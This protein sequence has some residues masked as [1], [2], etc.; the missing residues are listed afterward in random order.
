[1]RWFILFVSFGILA[2]Q[3]GH[4]GGPSPGGVAPR[5]G[6]QFEPGGTDP[7]EHGSYHPLPLHSVGGVDKIKVHDVAVDEGGGVWAATDALVVYLPRG[8]SPRRYSARD[9][10]ATGDTHATFA[11]V[12]AGRAGQAFIGTLG[13][14][15]DVVDVQ[16]SG[17][18]SVHHLTLTNP[19]H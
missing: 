12:G 11:G 8:S 10:L 13:R 5:S 6:N 1:M 4:A 14:Y 15:A 7:V 9:G 3:H 2:C 19:I 16:P 18:L 17:H